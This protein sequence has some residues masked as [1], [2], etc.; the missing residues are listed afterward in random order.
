M[1][2]TSGLDQPQAYIGLVEYQ[3]GSVV[4]RT[5]VKKSVGTVTAFAFDQGQGLS[6]HSAPYD[7]L[8]FVLEGTAEIKLAGVP[9][10]VKGG[11]VLRL[12]A[13]IPHALQAIERF[14]MLLVM[15]RG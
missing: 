8:V 1:T 7:A 13:G 15:I 3:E 12:P 10:S 9:H 5:L 11:E 6:E 14:K 2:E 4:S